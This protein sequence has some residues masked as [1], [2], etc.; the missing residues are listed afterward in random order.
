MCTRRDPIPADAGVSY[1][2]ERAQGAILLLRSRTARVNLRN[3]KHVRA[4]IKDNIDCWYEFARQDFGEEQAPEGSIVL[5]RGC[6]KTESWAAAAFTQRS[7]DASIFFNGG[8]QGFGPNLKLC[9]SWSR[10]ASSCAELRDSD[11]RQSSPI[12]RL[13]LE[14]SPSHLT[15][16]FPPEC[17]EC[18][19]VRVFRCWRRFGPLKIPKIIKAGSG[20]PGFPGNDDSGVSPPVSCNLTEEVGDDDNIF[21]TLDSDLSLVGRSCEYL[22][23]ADLERRV[24]IQWTMF[25]TISLK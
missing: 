22:A 3:T 5:V 8:L 16:K 20:P 21:V 9:G 19:F 24:N 4:Y 12:T 2:C 25:S 17:K 13:L 23:L 1:R 10:A 11:A 7:K 6:D 18:V 15:S 14:S